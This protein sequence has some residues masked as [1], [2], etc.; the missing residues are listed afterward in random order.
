MTPSEEGSLQGAERLLDSW[1]GSS[2]SK[3]TEY[4]PV[5]TVLSR[6]VPGDEHSWADEFAWILAHR[7][8]EFA[9]LLADLAADGQ[10]EP[11][12]LGAD[13]RVWDG[14]HRIFAA[15]VK[16]DTYIKVRHV[17]RCPEGD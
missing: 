15:V 10:R 3:D 8:T 16:G 17:G 2:A 9:D 11:V 7:R 5:G 12:D 13:G 14:H 6:W 4:L 1:T